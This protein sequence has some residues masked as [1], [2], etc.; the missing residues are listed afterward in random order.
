[1]LSFLELNGVKIESTDEDVVALGMGAAS[2]NMTQ[3]DVLTWIKE[4]KV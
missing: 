4:H 1:M 2:G 3:D